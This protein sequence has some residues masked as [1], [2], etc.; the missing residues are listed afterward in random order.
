MYQFYN[1]Y[2]KFPMQRTSC[3]SGFI[4]AH[5]CAFSRGQFDI[6]PH[7]YIHTYLSYIED[8][9]CLPTNNYLHT[10][11]HNMLSEAPK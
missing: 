9:A 4:I 6:W 3:R 11:V 10:C 7:A 5:S 2:K 1:G 8:D